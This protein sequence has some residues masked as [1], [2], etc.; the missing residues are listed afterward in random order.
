MSYLYAGPS[1]IFTD[2]IVKELYTRVDCNNCNECSV[3]RKR[4]Y[5]STIRGPF[6]FC[7]ENLIKLG[8]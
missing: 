1:K 3:G 8:D 2:L 4:V 6:F 5:G 7:Q